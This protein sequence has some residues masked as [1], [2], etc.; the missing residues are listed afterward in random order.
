VRIKKVGRQWPH[1]KACWPPSRS[2]KNESA[3]SPVSPASFTVAGGVDNLLKL[4]IQVSG[5]IPAPDAISTLLKPKAHFHENPIRLSFRHCFH[6]PSGRIHLKFTRTTDGEE[7]AHT[8]PVFPPMVTIDKVELI[9][10][11]SFGDG[12]IAVTVG[13]P[14][15][16]DLNLKVRARL[17][18]FFFQKTQQTLQFEAPLELTHDRSQ[19]TVVLVDNLAKYYRQDTELGTTSFYLKA[20]IAVIMGGNAACTVEGILDRKLWV[21][22]PAYNSEPEPVAMPEQFGW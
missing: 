16:L 20:D 11:Q 13:N 18:V 8:I 15:N 7:L 4:I 6:I 12:Q 10:G 14:D 22:S 5:F 1:S 17:G 21:Y 3:R 19:S 2:F 9:Q